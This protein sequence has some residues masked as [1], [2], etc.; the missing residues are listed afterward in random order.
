MSVWNVSNI[1][2]IVENN[3]YFYVLSVRPSMRLSLENLY[4]W[5]CL[6]ISFDTFRVN[7]NKCLFLTLDTLRIQAFSF[8]EVALFE[9]Y[10]PKTMGFVLEISV[11]G[12]KCLYVSRK[13]VFLVDTLGHSCL[14]T[15]VV[16]KTLHLY[17]YIYIY[18][19]TYISSVPSST[20]GHG[21]PR[22]DAWRPP[23]HRL[24]RG[25]RN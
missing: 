14:G 3:I 4:I 24:W 10:T 22:E 6:N 18:I 8:V 25:N 9:L 12:R 19:Y 21:K 15:N 5:T 23:A 1:F 17:I 20:G 13:M 2:I 7:R 16:F 11:A